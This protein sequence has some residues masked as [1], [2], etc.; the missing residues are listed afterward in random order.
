MFIQVPIDSQPCL[1]SSQVYL[2]GLVPCL[3][4]LPHNP[5]QVWDCD[6]HLIPTGRAH[7][8]PSEVSNARLFQ[9]KS[10]GR[11]AHALRSLT[12]CSHPIIDARGLSQNT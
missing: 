5:T 6:I 12:L 8:S 3:A 9:S 4:T 11:E 10:A 7:P 2:T 1:M